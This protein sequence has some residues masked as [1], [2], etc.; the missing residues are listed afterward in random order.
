[1][2]GNALNRKRN[3]RISPDLLPPAQKID[4]SETRWGFFGRTRIECDAEPGPMTPLGGPAFPR[5]FLRPRKWL[6][7][8]T[9]MVEAAG[10][11]PASESL[12]M[13]PKAPRR[14]KPRLKP[15]PEF[16]LAASAR[17][18]P[19]PQPDAGYATPRTGGSRAL[20]AINF[21]SRALPCTLGG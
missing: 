4:H 20:G 12:Q 21:P 15:S 16:S 2:N 19:G 14:L 10:I 1:M 8:K 3:L 18:L 17:V 9:E 5:V 13:I 6:K 11:E 7:S